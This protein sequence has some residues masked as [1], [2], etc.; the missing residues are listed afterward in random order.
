[1]KYG[2]FHLNSRAIVPRRMCTF[3]NSG[4]HYCK[5][6]SLEWKPGASG[7]GFFSVP[8]PLHSTNGM[9]VCAGHCLCCAGHTVVLRWFRRQTA[10]SQYFLRPR[11]H[12]LWEGWLVR[13]WQT[14]MRWSCWSWHRKSNSG[15]SRWGEG[16]GCRR[17]AECTGR[18]HGE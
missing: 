17:W 3:Q 1:M 12:A 13:S 4:S 5:H 11:G 2:R 8:P 14:D 15:F 9:P 10:I 6:S 18:R 16:R 7:G